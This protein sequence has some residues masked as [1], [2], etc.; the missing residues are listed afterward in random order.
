[1]DKRLL[2]G[3]SIVI[4]M[5][6]ILWWARRDVAPPC[7]NA[8][9]VAYAY[10]AYSL[11]KTGSDEHGNFMPLRLV[12]FN[13][14][15]MPLYSYTLIP[16]FWAFGTGD[17]VIRLPNY[18]ISILSLVGLFLLTRQLT[19]SITTSTVVGLILASTPWFLFLSRQAH[20]SI[21]V[22]LFA[23]WGIYFAQRFK[24]ELSARDALLSLACGVLASF[25]YHTG[26]LVVLLITGYLFYL[27]FLRYRSKKIPGSVFALWSSGMVLIGLCLLGIEGIYGAARVQSLFL[28]SSIGF[29]L[30]IN[31]LIQAFPVR[32]IFN[33]LT[34]G[35]YEFLNHYV[36]HFSFPFFNGSLEDNVRFGY[37]D[38]HALSFVFFVMAFVGIVTRL[39]K[40]PQTTDIFLCIF[41]FTA[42]LLSAM[43][44][45]QPSFGR[46]H[47]MLLPLVYFSGMGL[48]WSVQRLK[49]HYV[50]WIILT[51]LTGI[52][53]L[54][55][56]FGYSVMYWVYPKQAHVIRSWQ[57][58]Y[59]ELLTTFKS[60]ID[61]KKHVYMT[62]RHGQPYIYYLWYLKYDPSTYQKN[63]SYTEADEYGFSQVERFDKYVFNLPASKDDPDTLYIGYPDEMSDVVSQSKEIKLG[64]ES[65]FIIHD[66]AKN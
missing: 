21:L 55:Y 1:M 47:L 54:E 30:K 57:C 25:S 27:L 41:L 22:M 52:V 15:K 24:T 17:E 10:N 63:A 44:W 62:A 43:T 35:L 16:F 37:P 66:P 53:L 40:K 33:K 64:T 34:V 20:E 29:S 12:S 60:D 58:G 42:P 31:S 36:N 13:D 59:K 39:Q 2:T 4:L 56:I 51:G 19:K 50:G 11:M 48:V 28:T 32:I 26:R 38:I 14:F 45:T 8:D 61:Q 9:E 49:K 23:V 3:L 65:I 6:S 18:F 7:L 5:F 46:S